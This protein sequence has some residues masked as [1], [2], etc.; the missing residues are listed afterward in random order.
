MSLAHFN[1]FK[2]QSQVLQCKK[3]NLRHSRPFTKY[4]R[5]ANTKGRTSFFAVPC[6]GFTEFDY[7]QSF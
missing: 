4:L 6:I 7:Y 3:N 1:G 5:V 2:V